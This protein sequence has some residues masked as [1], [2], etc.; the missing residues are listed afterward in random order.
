M[1][2]FH[3][4]LETVEKFCFGVL[5]FRHEILREIFVDDAV[6]CREKGQYVLDKMTLIVVQFF[7][8]IDEVG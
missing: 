4:N 1:D 5:D 6:T 2:I 3:H 8:P 7:F